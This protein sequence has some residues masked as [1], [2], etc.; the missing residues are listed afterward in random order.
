MGNAGFPNDFLWGASSSAAQIEGGWQ[1]GGRTPSIWDIAPAKKVKQ[2]ESC[3][4]A[5]DHYHRWREDVALM[6]KMGLRSYRFSVSWSRIMPEEGKVNPTGIKFYSDLVDTLLAAGVEPLVTIY[7]WDMPLWVYKKGGWLS[8]AIIPLFQEYTRVIVEALS[9]R[10]K[11]WIPMN[12]P[13]CFI[14]NAYLQGVH[15]PF[16]RDYLALSKLTRICM[17]AHG[18]A[19]AIG[20]RFAALV[21]EALGRIG[22]ER[23]AYHDA[24]ISQEYGLSTAMPRGLET[25]ELIELMGRDKKSA[26]SLTFMLD[27]D[28][29]I[30]MVRD[31]DPKIVAECLGRME[32]R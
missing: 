5:C 9:D 32:V 4:T 15:A 11:W 20:L 7:H 10:V 18:E 23:V 6:Q 2:G 27:S 13:G 25:S 19:V 3:H 29:G 22:P 28:R 30:E 8:E 31:V 16:R 12:E 26:G 17:L 24:V 14:M 1:E 21:A